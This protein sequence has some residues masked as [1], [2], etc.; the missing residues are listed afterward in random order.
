MTATTRQTCMVLAEL[1]QKDIELFIGDGE[2]RYVPRQAMTTELHARLQ[3][4][5]DAILTALSDPCDTALAIVDDVLEREGFDAALDLGE[6]FE[7]RAAVREFEGDVSR[8]RAECGALLDTCY[9]LNGRGVA[10]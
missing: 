10:E 8:E 7:E 5:R 2:L 1:R 3:A 6:H 9:R 4:H